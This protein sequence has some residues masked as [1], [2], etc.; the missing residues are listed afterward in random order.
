VLFLYRPERT[1]TF[2]DL[3][4]GAR[5]E[6]V[7]QDA[8]RS[9]WAAPSRGPG[10]RAWRVRL[11]IVD[12]CGARLSPFCRIPCPAGHLAALQ[13]TP[14]LGA[15]SQAL[16]GWCVN[17]TRRE[18]RIEDRTDLRSAGPKRRKS[19]GWKST[20]MSDPVV[21]LRMIKRNQDQ[22]PSERRSP[23]SAETR[24]PDRPEGLAGCPRE[25]VARIPWDSSPGSA[26]TR[27]PDRPEG[28]AGCPRESVARI[29]WDSLPG[30]AGI[31]CLVGRA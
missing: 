1:R 2:Q 6:R 17:Q 20:K 29:P 31:R 18:I 4:I 12:G 5:Y 27:R 19:S 22:T 15:R 14:H 8:R 25:S 9:G 7:W 3:A 24:R 28:S 30:S 23:G 10:S 26:E 16:S 11:Q 13:V 21:R